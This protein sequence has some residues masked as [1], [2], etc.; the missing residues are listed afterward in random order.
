MTA[1]KPLPTEHQLITIDNVSPMKDLGNGDLELKEE[2]GDK[3][4]EEKPFETAEPKSEKF[5]PII[6][7][8]PIS[9]EDEEMNE[10]LAMENVPI[11]K[12]A[13]R[14]QDDVFDFKNH[15]ARSSYCPTQ[16]IAIFL[17]KI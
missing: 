14:S 12:S 17:R 10:F 1:Q 16:C 11:A 4:V 8:T 6:M 15:R 2:A 5:H 13:F 7:N 3:I 9:Y